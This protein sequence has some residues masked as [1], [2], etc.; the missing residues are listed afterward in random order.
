M[1]KSDLRRQ[2]FE[3]TGKIPFD[4][5]RS[6]TGKIEDISPPLLKKF[7]GDIGSD[8]PNLDLSHEEILD[9]LRLTLPVNGHKAPRNIALMFFSEDPGK[10]FPGMRI[11]VVRFINGAGGDLID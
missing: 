1:S 5:R 10:F 8:I 9:K 7:L 2:L 3:H 11:E 4:D 6:L